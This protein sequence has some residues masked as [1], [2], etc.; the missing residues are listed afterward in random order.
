[1]PSVLRK[2]RKL[3]QRFNRTVAPQTRRV[4]ERRHQH[5]RHYKWQRWR[6]MFQQWQRKVRALRAFFLRFALL[7]VCGL[8]L[9]IVGIGLFSSVL[10]VREI[11]VARSDPRLDTVLI[12]QALKPLFGRRMPILS[13]EDIPPMLSTELPSLHRSAVP[14]LSTVTIR[15]DYPSALQIKITLR[16]LAYRLSIETAD[17]K[18]PVIPQAGSGADFLTADGLY[19]VY[20]SATSGSGASLP[21]LHIV[22]W[23]IKPDPWKPLLATD[24]L[25]AM[26]KTEELL[27]SQFGQTITKRTIFL[28]GREYH[29][30]TRTLSLWFDLRSPISDQLQRYALFLKTVPPG[31][32]KEYVDLRIAHKL[33]YK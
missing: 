29:L 27:Q 23:S 17:Q 8:L 30:Q 26:K 12:Q 25:R 33:V 13:V 16:P 18:K 19:V 2:P 22:D 20:T 5:V 14:D 7:F 28:R 31:G 11:R 9:L 1:M 32:A 3:P 10:N 4:V 15:K 21:Q 24:F 6:R